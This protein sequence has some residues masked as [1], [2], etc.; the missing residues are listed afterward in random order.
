MSV[1]K[2]VVKF[3]KDG[4]KFVSSVDWYDYTLKELCRAAL[5]DVGK[6]VWSCL[7]PQGSVEA[8]EPSWTPAPCP[9]PPTRSVDAVSSRPS[10]SSLWAQ[11]HPLQSG[12]L[13]SLPSKLPACFPAIT[14][15]ATKGA[16]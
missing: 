2:S 8:R 3:D 16:A 9:V 12:S 11:A 14:L 13:E 15:T 4:V 7:C 5:R 10:L 1:P 6:F